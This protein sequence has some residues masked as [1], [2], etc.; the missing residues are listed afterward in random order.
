MN[1][2][3]LNFILLCGAVLLGLLSTYL[4]DSTTDLNGLAT[5]NAPTLT[6][7][8][9]QHILYG[10]TKGGGH[11]HSA[12]RPCKSE[13]PEDWNEDTI[14]ATVKKLAAND[15]ANW[16]RQDN[17]YHVSEQTYDTLNIRIVL[18]QNRARI[19]TAYPTNVKRNPCY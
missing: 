17:G 12:N 16:Q 5:Q 4:S 14:I 11:H 8:R 7:A 18:N 3:R 15:N 9:Q 10:D 2:K 6:A 19:I 1:K 13:F